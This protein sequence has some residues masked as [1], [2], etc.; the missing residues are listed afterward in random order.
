ME[1]EDISANTNAGIGVTH[2]LNDK[3]NYNEGNLSARGMQAVVH[4]H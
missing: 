3:K 1:D 2:Q 4:K